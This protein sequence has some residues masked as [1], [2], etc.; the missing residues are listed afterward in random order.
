[1]LLLDRAFDRRTNPLERA[2]DVTDL[3]GN[4]FGVRPKGQGPR[5][6]VV[7]GAHRIGSH[8][9]ID[10]RRSICMGLVGRCGAPTVEGTEGI[11]S[12]EDERDL[13]EMGS[14]RVRDSLQF[15]DEF[16]A[17][18]KLGDD[19]VVA[20]AEM[21]ARHRRRKCPGGQARVA[22]VIQPRAEEAANH[23]DVEVQRERS[24]LDQASCQCRFAR[25]RWPVEQDENWHP[26][27]GNDRTLAAAGPVRQTRAMTEGAPMPRCDGRV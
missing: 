24:N 20:A 7:H 23:V 10:E 6:E 25:R 2:L 27:H 5:E 15:V 1:M 14:G 4:L 11:V 9:T 12:A 13:D 17:G 19:D 21:G 16:H 22:R 3:D 18:E 26:T 8:R